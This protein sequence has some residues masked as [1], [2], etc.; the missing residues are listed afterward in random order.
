MEKKTKALAGVCRLDMSGQL[1]TETSRLT[2]FLA[3]LPSIE[4]LRV[5][6]SEET[7]A[8]ANRPMEEL[9]PAMRRQ[10]IRMTNESRK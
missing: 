3:G 7:N 2:D 4:N 8:L 1:S 5:Y 6:T 9:S 10:L